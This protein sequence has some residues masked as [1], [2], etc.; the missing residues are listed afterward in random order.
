MGLVQLAYCDLTR[1]LLP[2]AM[3]HATTLAVALS[4]VVA[5]GV[6]GD[7]HRAAGA[8]LGGAGLFA[9]LL[10]FNLLNPAWMAFGD[11]RLAPAVGLGLAW[12]SPMA[13]VEGFFLANVLTA[14]IG[15]VLMAIRRGGR[16]TAMP[17]GLYLA[18]ASAVIVMA[19]N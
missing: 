17:F 5:A 8:A 6:T 18:V 15:L 4:L 1:L 11:V 7:W 9:L 3:V 12:I 16:K 19:W 10:T 14:V 13:L 2:K